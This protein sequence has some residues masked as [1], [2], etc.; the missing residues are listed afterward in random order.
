MLYS[1]VP[2]I[3]LA[4][5]HLSFSTAYINESC[6]GTAAEHVEWVGYNNLF[7]FLLPNNTTS[8]CPALD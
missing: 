3:V 4:Y 7:I 8:L 2:I 1:P 6:I 5:D